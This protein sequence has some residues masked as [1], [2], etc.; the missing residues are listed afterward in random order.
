MHS[1][2][3]PSAATSSASRRA[4][5]A[6]LPISTTDPVAAPLLSRRASGTTNAPRRASRRS[7]TTAS[8]GN[9]A[10]PSVVLM[11]SFSKFPES[12]I[13]RP[14]DPSADSGRMRISDLLSHPSHPSRRAR[15]PSTSPA[16]AAIR[17]LDRVVNSSSTD[18][19]PRAPS[20]TS[21]SDPTGAPRDPAQLM[22]AVLRLRDQMD[23][24]AAM[25]AEEGARRRRSS[26]MS[27]RRRTTVDRIS[28]VPSLTEE[29]AE[30]EDSSEL[31]LTAADNLL[32]ACD[33]V[34][35]VEAHMHP[36]LPLHPTPA[37]RPAL[38]SPGAYFAAKSHA[39]GR[40]DG[41]RLP[42]AQRP[43]FDSPSTRSLMPNTPATEDGW[44]AEPA[45]ARTGVPKPV[46]ALGRGDEDAVARPTTT[47]AAGMDRSRRGSGGSTGSA[48]ETARRWTLA[49]AP[50]V[51]GPR[52]PATPPPPPPPHSH[53]VASAPRATP[54]PP[55]R[56]RRTT[57]ASHDDGE[58]DSTAGAG[59]T[60]RVPRTDRTARRT[61]SHLATTPPS[62]TRR[63]SSSAATTP[64][65]RTSTARP[66]AMIPSTILRAPLSPAPSTPTAR[67]STSSFGSTTP[68]HIALS[69]TSLTLVMADAY[70]ALLTITQLT[71]KRRARA[72]I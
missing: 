41:Q 38:L 9:D 7:S 67:D 56:S 24:V 16:T 8:A 53:A 1:A 59:A 46:F 4:S 21:G 37:T 17:D 31:S 55:P 32:Q 54:P 64:R 60:P 10:R 27:M 47:A 20:S 68:S 65:R 61:L 71:P 35:T 11:P 12:P 26:E 51:A 18:S 52:P 2:Q 70:R 66:T 57:T 13:S 43:H 6:H 40:L 23:D 14:R 69:T 39:L 3:I 34:M 36:D 15:S 63:G 58:T 28:G 45:V 44:P 19:P 62:P 22:Q 25:A 50:A 33:S 72:W 29:E 5:L 42:P 48:G 49:R 30:D